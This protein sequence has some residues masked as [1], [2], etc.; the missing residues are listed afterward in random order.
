MT[1]ALSELSGQPPIDPEA[2]SAV[3]DFLDYTEFFPSDLLRSLTL[4]GKL[5]ESYQTDSARVHQL[6]KQY[7]SL[8][9]FSHTERSSPK[10]LRRDISTSLDHA[11]KCRESALAEASRICNVA[12]GLYD[13]LVGI[14]SKL[15]AMPSPPSRDPTPIPPHRSPNATRTRKLDTER[16]PQ[17]KLTLESEK[18]GRSV[19]QTN[20]ASRPKNTTRRIIVP[21]EIMPPYDPNSPGASIASDSEPDRVSSP[22]EAPSTVIKLA[23]KPP[24]LKMNKIKL[25]KTPKIRPPG[26]MGTNVHSTVAGISVS[27]AMAS[28]TPPPQNPQVG[29]EWA[30]WFELTEYELNQLRRKMKKNAN[31]QPSEIMK[32]RELSERGRGLDNYKKAKTEAEA[33][34]EQILDEPPH[35]S[36]KKAQPLATPAPAP[37]Q[38]PAPVATSVPVPIPTPLLAPPLAVETGSEIMSVTP[39]L[40]TQTPQH[41]T[42]IQSAPNGDPSSRMSPEA[43]PIVSNKGAQSDEKKD[44]KKKLKREAMLKEQAAREELERQK[45][46][47]IIN[48]GSKFLEELYRSGP[49]FSPT[50]TISLTSKESKPSKPAR[51]RKRETSGVS[52]NTPATENNTE[53]SDLATVTK[54]IKLIPSASEAPPEPTT[55]PKHQTTLETAQAQTVPDQPAEAGP[56]SI[57]ENTAERSE[58]LVGEPMEGVISE[59]IPAEPI[60]VSHQST[61]QV[62]LAP[63]GPAAATVSKSPPQKYPNTTPPPP[64]SALPEQ[65][66]EPMVDYVVNPAKDEKPMDPSESTPEAEE[67]DVAAEESKASLLLSEAAERKQEEPKSHLNPEP[68]PDFEPDL[69][70]QPELENE[71][72]SSPN[73][74]PEH[75]PEPAL[76]PQPQFETEANPDPDY[77][78]K[79]AE[80]Q[81]ASKPRPHSRGSISIRLTSKK[82]ASTEPA[83]RRSSDRRASNISLP[84]G[85]SQTT[86]QTAASRRGKRNAPGIEITNL[87]GGAKI[88]FASKKSGIEV[89]DSRVSIPDST[90]K[91]TKNNQSKKGASVTAQDEEADGEDEDDNEYYCWCGRP[92]F[93]AMVACDGGCKEEWFHL[94]CTTLTQLPGR[95]QKWFCKDCSE[96]MGV[97]EFGKKLSTK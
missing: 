83:K 72:G 86:L 78:A 71:T 52:N 91:S 73:P 70:P 48:S 43:K 82:A 31:W 50:Q 76:Q 19:R 42:P 85:S 54:K 11:L 44:E 35:Q 80:E 90:K 58:E 17:L 46:T 28:Q 8:S 30:P 81:E 77:E 69:E 53:A 7:G 57:G 51:K 6:T 23:E 20:G 16:T 75:R 41:A 94:E 64:A 18:A 32:V 62:P 5:D 2:Q 79:L 33:N 37:K 65:I 66:D 12:D 15:K 84:S 95:R 56:K 3:T 1:D 88:R 67:Q 63:E 74:D 59:P 61:V 55:Q 22:V 13:K 25:P 4:I 89:K 39:E 45:A 97:T 24:T 21:G 9:S 96:Q 26:I 47:Q 40:P 92:S 34:G 68:E 38:A 10:A 27:N 14:R 93:G 49:M 60:V 36:Q 29:S 87:E